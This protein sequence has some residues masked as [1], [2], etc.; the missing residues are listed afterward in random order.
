MLQL[1]VIC[2]L[3]LMNNKGCAV[4]AETAAVAESTPTTVKS[5]VIIELL[6]LVNL[7]KFFLFC[8]WFWLT[9]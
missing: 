9:Q 8:L 3:A 2:L 6:I 5:C 4:L 1:E 7:I